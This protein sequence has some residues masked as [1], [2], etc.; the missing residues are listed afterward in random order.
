MQRII[1]LDIG[2]VRI[3][4][5]VS[6]PLGFFAQGVAVLNAREDWLLELSKITAQYENP[7]ILIGLPRRTDGSEGPEAVRMRE[8]AEKIKEYF[9][10][11]ETEFWDERFTT[12]IAQQ[13]LLEADVSRAGRKTKVD[14]IAATLLLQSY[15]DRGRN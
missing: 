5:A 13:A 10:E 6:D 15:L 2:T 14:K 12:T 9:P 3:G 8:T 11:L 1:A 4:V 7:K